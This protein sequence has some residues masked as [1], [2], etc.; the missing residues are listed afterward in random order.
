[1]YTA[2]VNVRSENEERSLFRA[3]LTEIRGIDLLKFTS[4]GGGPSS[5]FTSSY[6]S[7]GINMFNVSFPT[8]R[9]ICITPP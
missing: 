9:D 2:R 8:W 4:T 5:G 1:V 3:F 7:K 6:N